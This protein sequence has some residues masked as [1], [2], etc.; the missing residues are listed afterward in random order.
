MHSHAAQELEAAQKAQAAAATAA[1]DGGDGGGND[2]QVDLSSRLAAIRSRLS[3]VKRKNHDEVIEEDLRLKVRPVAGVL[4][5]MRFER[6][7]PARAL[8]GLARHL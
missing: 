3:Q 2:G 5:F 1:E 8:A 4:L 7:S 6:L